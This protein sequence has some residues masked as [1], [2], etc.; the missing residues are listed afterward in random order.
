M[1]CYQ[2]NATDLC[3]QIQTTQQT[4]T[5]IHIQKISKAKDKPIL[6]LSV[7]FNLVFRTKQ[8]QNTWCDN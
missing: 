7:L 8:T 4:Q 3:L 5:H 6:N 1:R 2:D